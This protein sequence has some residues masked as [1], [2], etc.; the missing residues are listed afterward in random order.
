MGFIID[1]TARSNEMTLEDGLNLR[2]FHVLWF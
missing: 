2:S 1:L